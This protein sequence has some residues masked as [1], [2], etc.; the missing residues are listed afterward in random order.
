MSIHSNFRARL[1]WMDC[2][3]TITLPR[4]RASGQTTRSSAGG[5]GFG[6]VFGLDSCFF[7][8]K[9][10]ELCGRFISVLILSAWQRDLRKFDHLRHKDYVRMKRFDTYTLD[11]QVCVDQ[12]IVERKPYALVS[13]FHRRTWRGWLL[14]CFQTGPPP[15]GTQRPM[16]CASEHLLALA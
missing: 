12:C 7:F 4:S 13:Q 2:L 1:T 16:R 5:G 6:R 8:V 10:T 14:M 11:K 3:C 9:E 15:L